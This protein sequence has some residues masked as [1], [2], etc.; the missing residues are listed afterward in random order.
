MV[1]FS[2]QILPS[3]KNASIFDMIKLYA[4]VVK[5]SL[6]KQKRDYD[7][8]DKQYNSGKWNR[9]FEDIDFESLIGN[10]SRKDIDKS[11]VV[12]YNDKLVYAVEKDFAKKYISK[13]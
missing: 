9:K 7:V 12:A 5:L 1:K 4:Y 6:K 13:M 8:I 10:Y 3:Y 2:Y 11:N